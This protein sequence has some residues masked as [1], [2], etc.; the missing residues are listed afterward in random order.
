MARS[1]TDEEITLAAGYVL[2]DLDAEEQMRAEQ[3]LET[4]SAFAREVNALLDSLQL[5]PPAIAKTPPSP[6]LRD[7]V[8]TTHRVESAPPSLSQK[9]WRWPILL[10]TAAGLVA[11]LLGVD[12]VRLRSRLRLAQ[13]PEAEHVAALMQNPQS[14]LIA[15]EGEGVPAAGTLLFTVGNW[16]EVIVSLSG[17]P[18]LPPDQ[19]Y[20]LWL[21]LETGEFIFCGEFRPESE[22]STVIRLLPPEQPP[23]GVKTTGIFVTAD[24][25]SSSLEPIGDP[26]VQGTI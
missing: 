15:L 10:V 7:Q 9:R 3:L 23:E 14:R 21:L 5:V 26:I 8:L 1:L 12:N 4:H 19:V 16:Q 11:V 20:R 25:A 17:L 6:S 13:T 24:S 2:G 22:G 18:L